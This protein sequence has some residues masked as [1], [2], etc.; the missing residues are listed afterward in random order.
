MTTKPAGVPWVQYARKAGVAL[1]LGVL[2]ALG[3]LV[4]FTL[5]GSDGADV[6]TTNE[7]VT[8]AYL[9]VMAVA[10]SLGVYAAKNRFTR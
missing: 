8:V 10:S 7:W 9:S 6:V 5:D 3:A 1:L 4:G 2:A